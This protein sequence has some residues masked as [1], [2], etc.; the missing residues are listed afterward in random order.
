MK[1]FI[2]LFLAGFVLSSCSDQNAPQKA[3]GQQTETPAPTANIDK[4]TI[5]AFELNT[6]K[7]G[8]D[9]QSGIV[10][11]IN[12]AVKCTINPHFSDCAANK[13]Y[14]PSFIFMEDESLKR[15]TKQSYQI[16]KL[17]PLPDGTIEV[18]T[19]SHCNGNWFGLCNGNII[20]VMENKNGRWGVKDLYA[21]AN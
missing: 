20:F 21:L 8:C 3:T 4:E 2:F 11:A 15:P 19:Q 14:M 10:C 17:K 9:S 6:L 12:D 13:D 1:S 18:Y 7:P 5:F 16:S